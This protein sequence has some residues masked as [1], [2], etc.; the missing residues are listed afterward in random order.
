MS[1]L[2]QVK[3]GKGKETQ[4]EGEN[5]GLATMF[6]S[7]TVQQQ[8]VPP[9]TTACTRLSDMYPFY[10]IVMTPTLYQDPCLLYHEIR[11]EE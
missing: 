1:G 6:L 2:C 8:L 5:K 4:R 10:F 3:R 11:V 9:F 7:A